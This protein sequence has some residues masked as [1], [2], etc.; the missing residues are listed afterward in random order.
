MRTQELPSGGC[1][2]VGARE[3]RGGKVGVV[4][5]ASDA[6]Q[7]TVCEVNVALAYPVGGRQKQSGHGSGKTQRRLR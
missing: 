5:S 1:C 4:F 3:R 6:A 2:N 7:Y